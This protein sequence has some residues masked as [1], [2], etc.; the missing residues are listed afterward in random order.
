[1]HTFKVKRSEHADK[2]VTCKVELPGGPSD[3]D[4]IKK[5]FGSIVRVFEMANKAWTVSCQRGARAK[6][7][8]NDDQAGAQAYAEAYCDN[9]ARAVQVA[10]KITAKQQDEQK[11]TKGQIESLRKAGMDVSALLVD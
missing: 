2:P 8:K 4:L 9:G 7:T 1:M 5:R 10:P 6:M 11:F 3:T